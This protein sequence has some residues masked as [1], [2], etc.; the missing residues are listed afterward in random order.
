MIFLYSYFFFFFSSRRRHTR[1]LCD[2]SSD[3]CSSD[4]LDQRQLE[5]DPALAREL[6]RVVGRRQPRDPPADDDQPHGAPRTRSPSIAIKVGWSFTAAARWSAMPCA[7]AIACASTSRS[8]R[9]SM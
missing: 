7:R 4:L 2:W 3:V 9:S 8:Y 5:G 1:S 6:E